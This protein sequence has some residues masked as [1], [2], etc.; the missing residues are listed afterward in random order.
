MYSMEQRKQ[1][2]HDL[3]KGLKKAF[4][5][6]NQY[7]V[8]IFGSFLTERYNEISDIDVGV[9]SLDKHLIFQIYIYLCDYFDNIGIKH[10]IV[11]MEL[12]EHQYINVN[13]ILY[14][15]Y[16][17]TNYCPDELIHYTS[18]MIELYGTNPMETIRKKIIQEVGLNDSNW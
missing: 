3:E 13:I 1:I 17:F 7:N 11:R 12:D 8:L 15:E 18:K 9:F 14:H 4:P 16:E 5:Q 6:T 10:D 2:V